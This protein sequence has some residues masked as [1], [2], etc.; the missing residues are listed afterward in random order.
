MNDLNIEIINVRKK[1]IPSIAPIRVKDIYS[2]NKDEFNQLYSSMLPSDNVGFAYKSYHELL[3]VE[4]KFTKPQ[5]DTS[6]SIRI[7]KETPTNIKVYDSVV[8]HEDSTFS[9]E[10]YTIIDAAIS[11]DGRMLVFLHRELDPLEFS[12]L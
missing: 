5:K 1:I 7:I 2:D 8:E 3:E 4:I 6:V 9:M 10:S 12:E 11:A